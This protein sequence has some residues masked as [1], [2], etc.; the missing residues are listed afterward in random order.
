[1]VI[2]AGILRMPAPPFFR[3][4]VNEFAPIVL[5]RISALP[6]RRLGPSFGPYCFQTI[7]I[8]IAKRTVLRV[9][10]RIYDL[11]MEGQDVTT[12]G[13]YCSHKRIRRHPPPN[14]GIVPTRSEVHE[15][16]VG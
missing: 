12:H 7:G 1:M 14:S 10:V 11:A 13:G 6:V 16:R 15:I 4:L 8:Q 5:P 2:M 9:S 3:S